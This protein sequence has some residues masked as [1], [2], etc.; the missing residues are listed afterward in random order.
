MEYVYLE[1]R[2]PKT[3]AVKGDRKSRYAHPGYWSLKIITETDDL[4][5]LMRKSLPALNWAFEIDTA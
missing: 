3:K 1:H 2:S 5:K 4:G